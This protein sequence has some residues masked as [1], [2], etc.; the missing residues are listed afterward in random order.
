MGFIN[1]IK[2][3]ISNTY[4]FIKRKI[5]VIKWIIQTRKELKIAREI[6][7]VDEKTIPDKKIYILIPHPDDEW[8]GCSEIIKDKNKEVVLVNLDMGKNDNQDMRKRRQ[9]ELSAIAHEFLRDIITISV[10]KEEQLKELIS[11]NRNACFMLPFFMDWNDSHVEM[12]FLLRKALVDIDLRQLEIAMYQVSC[13]IPYSLVNAR[14]RQSQKDYNKKWSLFR[15]IY[16]TQYNIIYPRFALHERINGRYMGSFSGEVFVVQ[17]ADIW[18]KQFNLLL[19]PEEK[20]KVKN[21]LNDI[22]LLRKT[23]TT[24]YLNKMVNSNEDRTN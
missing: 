16:K 23:I 8:I 19:T 5:Q 2:S 13:P 4:F 20:E 7:A 15:K 12:M 6:V 18:K 24:I 22:S 10:N 11:Q 3:T 9:E 1:I 17:T 14:C 21:N